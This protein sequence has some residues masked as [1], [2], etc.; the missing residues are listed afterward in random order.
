MRRTRTGP[1]ATGRRLRSLT[2]AALVAG[3]AGALALLS[4]CDSSSDNDASHPTT[5]GGPPSTENF[6]GSLPS[7]LDSLASAAQ[8]TASA[9][10]SS[11]KAAAS[12]FEASVEAAVGGATDEAKKELAK[13]DG[14]GNAVNDVQLTGFP[15]AKT[16]GLNAVLVSITNTSDQKASFAVKVEFADSSGAVVDS[17]VVGARDVEAGKRAQ[18]VA[19]STKDPGKTLFPRVAQAQ[20]Y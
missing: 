6:S 12:S 7:P 19:F 4:A 9:A 8:Q 20:R 13:V 5:P 1:A 2:A 11:A 17:T 14:Q 18:P 16:G 10:Q 15:R 3:T